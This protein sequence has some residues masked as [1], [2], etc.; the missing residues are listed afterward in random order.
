MMIGES[1]QQEFEAGG[2]IIS[3]V[4]KQMLA[5]HAC[6]LADSQPHSPFYLVPDSS[7]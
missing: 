1:G 3:T 2:H 6:L 5:I 7:A 4:K